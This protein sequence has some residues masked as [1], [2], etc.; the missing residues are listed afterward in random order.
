M[1]QRP[2]IITKKKQ[3]TFGDRF[4]RL[5][6][7][8]LNHP[9]RKPHSQLEKHIEYELQ[10]TLDHLAQHREQL[11]VQQRILAQERFY[12]YWDLVRQKKEA[13]YRPEHPNQIDQLTHRLQK[14]GREQ[15]TLRLQHTLTIERLQGRLVQLMSQHAL[16]TPQPH[17]DRTALRST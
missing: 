12:T 16:T 13:W 15:R 11:Q 1:L 7:T 3:R 6:K 2:K 8:I 4:E 10:M 17:G 14:I 5:T 9:S